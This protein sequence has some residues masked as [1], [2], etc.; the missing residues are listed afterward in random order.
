MVSVT[1]RSSKGAELTHAE[2]DAN[3]TELATTSTSGFDIVLVAGQSNMHGRTTLDAAIDTAHSSVWQFG[4]HSATTAYYRKIF[5]GVDPLHMPDMVNTGRVGP[6]AWFAK[7]HKQLTGRDVLLVPAA[8]GGT[9]L[10][11][12]TP[13]WSSTAPGSLYTN[14]ITQSNLA[15][16]AALALHPGSKFVG[17]IWFQGETDGDGAVTQSAYASA[18][19]SLIAGFRAG[20]TGASS[21]WFV[22]AQMVPEAISTRAGYSVIDLA[23]KQVRDNV[24]GTALALTNDLTGYSSDNLHFNVGNGIRIVGTRLAESVA[25]AKTNT[26]VAAA[27][28]QVLGLSAGT[29]GTTSV[30]LTWSIPT[31]GGIAVDYF[32]EYKASASGDWLLFADGASTTPSSTVTGLIASTAYDFR[33]SATNATG[34]GPVS[35]TVSATTA[36][37]LAAPGQVTGLTAGTAGTT[38]MP[39]TWTAP[40]TGGA[41]SDYVVEYKASASGTWLLFT[42]GVSVTPSATVTGLTSDTSYDFRVSATNATGTGTASATATA[43]TASSVTVPG[44]V[45]SLATGT[46]TSGIV[47]LT[48]SAPITGSAPT[49]YTVEYKATASGTW[50]PFTDGVSSATGASVTGLTPATAY[51]FR[52][53]ALNSAGSGAVSG[54]LSATTASDS[55]NIYNFESDTVGAAPSGITRDSDGAT[56][57]TPVV[58]SSGMPAGMTGK[59]MSSIPGVSTNTLAYTFSSFSNS[60]NQRLTWLRGRTGSARDGFTLRAHGTKTNAGNANYSNVS[61]G[62]FFQ[63]SDGTNQLRIFRVGTSSLT[64][65]GSTVSFTHPPVCYFRASVIGSTITFENSTDNITWNTSHTITDTTY[66]V[67]GGIQYVSGF[68]YANADKVFIDDVAYEAL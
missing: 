58:V 52:V 12:G 65:L 61:Q 36:A 6:A 66:S 51:D 28:S 1:T 15:V 42:D 34:T 64:A 11:T 23:H 47:P 3:F 16:T 35:A 18:L 62:Y 22:M 30:P 17:T 10:V 4:G 46:P 68:D 40:A 43:T 20:I 45:Q 53:T 21:S 31:L 2:V 5:S 13:A 59:A 41:P 25:I 9:G 63:T 57:T 24:A 27:P 56:P 29:P 49:D 8:Q 37:S 55:T 60:Q 32:V 14:A 19:T 48:W 54:T 26:G 50:L 67:A 38:T 39:L 7:T 33:V 44:A